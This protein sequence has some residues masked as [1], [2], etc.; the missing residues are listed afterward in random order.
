MTRMYY[1]KVGVKKTPSP[2]LEFRVFIITKEPIPFPE[3]IFKEVLDQMEFIFFSVRYARE[4]NTI[5]YI[6]GREINREIDEDEAR[7]YLARTGVDGKY[8]EYYRQ[9]HF[10]LPRER[11]RIYNEL[12][13]RTTEI[14]IPDKTL[15]YKEWRRSLSEE[16]FYEDIE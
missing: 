4:Q 2:F 8:G 7:L 6:Q 1:S 15:R 5:Y 10:F 16:V 13:I 14:L 9:A 12:D 3:R 11:E